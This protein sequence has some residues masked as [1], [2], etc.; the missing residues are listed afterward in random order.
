M[1]KIVE[2]YLRLKRKNKDALYLFKIGNFY[3]FIG[4]DADYINDYMVLKK[5]KF[6]GEYQKCGFP[7]NRIEDYERVFQKQN[8]NVIRIDDINTCNII[9]ELKNIDLDK[10]SYKEAI[11]LLKEI[12]EY[13]E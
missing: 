13:Y 4:E 7:I 9:N 10:L 2:E 1:S 3:T 11:E 6:S 8:L 12:K 5:T